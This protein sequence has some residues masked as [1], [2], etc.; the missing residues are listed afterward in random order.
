MNKNKVTEL[1]LPCENSKHSGLD[2][3]ACRDSVEIYLKGLIHMQ[4]E[5]LQCYLSKENALKLAD[6]IY[7]HFNK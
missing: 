6:A 4:D 2:L 3:W 1:E 7:Q 5:S